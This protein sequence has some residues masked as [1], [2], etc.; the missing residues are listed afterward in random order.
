M[1]KKKIKILLGLFYLVILS[2]FL[3]FLFSNVDYQDIKSIKILQ[4]NIDK[5]NLIKEN[6]LILLIFI[7][8]IFTIIWV[9]FL[10]F[11]T[12]IALIGGFIFG[13]WVGT[14]LVTI[15]LTVGATIL[16]LLGK[17]FF[18]IFLKEKLL[19]KFQNFENM[20][21]KKQLLVMIVFRFIGFVPFFLANLL[22]VI[23]NIN[24][25]NYFF[26]TF[27][28]ILPSIFIIVSLGSGLSMAIYHFDTF[29]SFFGLISLP[30]IYLPILGF[31]FLVIFA[32]VY[33]NFYFKKNE[34]Y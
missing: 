21:K 11:G 6:N 32:F 31:I 23:F 28:G 15:S 26:G 10:G 29:P 12:P 3:Y 34:K 7:F 19:L 17:Y 1:K 16:Y 2:G 20:F 14:F 24:L 30:E 25:K 18:Y 27:L 13:K 22:P 8:F 9:S 5:L 4:K 33:K